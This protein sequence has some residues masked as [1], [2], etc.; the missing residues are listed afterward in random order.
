MNKNSHNY[1][2]RDSAAAHLH[3]ES[4]EYTDRNM[5]TLSFD[6]ILNTMLEIIP[7]ITMSEMKKKINTLREQ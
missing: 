1:V 5:R 7:N 2:Y 4:K 3:L 6:M